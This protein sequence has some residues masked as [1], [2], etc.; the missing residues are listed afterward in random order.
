MPSTPAFYS[1]PS[2]HIKSKLN[3]LYCVAIA[4][5]ALL[6]SSPA[7][8][9][10]E[11]EIT[12]NEVETNWS[13]YIN[14]GF[15][16]NS[17][18]SDTF[19]A[20][21][22]Y[23][24]SSR[25]SYKSD[26]GSLLLTVGGE[27]QTLHGKESSFYDPLLEYRTPFHV[28]SDTLFLRGSVGV[29]LP[30]NHYTKLDRLQYAPRVAGYLYWTPT[31]SMS[32]YLSPR[33]RYN[34]Y[35]YKTAGQRVLIEHQFDTLLDAQWQITDSLYFDVSGRYRISKNYYGRRM[36]DQFTFAQELGWEF[37]PDWVVAVGHNNSGKFYDPEI[38]PSQGFEVYDKKSSTFYLSLTTYL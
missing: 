31:D 20:Y 11:Y 26:W 22:A 34:A 28:F 1:L 10:N 5:L 2:Q 7:N 30:G 3:S 15:T 14:V 27:K 25:V 24:F 13:G 16:R 12:R 33:Y 9:V 17:Y 36:D 18:D 19:S 21:Q 29:Y 8:A 4:G 6:G 35:Q 23:N 38:G 32:F 37:T